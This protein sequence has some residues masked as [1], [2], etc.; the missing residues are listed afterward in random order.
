MNISVPAG[1]TK[2]KRA[3]S[4]CMAT[5]Q[6]ITFQF[7]S[8]R[9]SESSQAKAMRTTIPDKLMTLYMDPLRVAR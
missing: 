7:T 6:I 8:L 5:P 9:F 1:T 3:K 4:I 2:I